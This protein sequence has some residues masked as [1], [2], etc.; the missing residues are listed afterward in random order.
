M[1]SFI[2]INVKNYRLISIAKARKL[3]PF[4]F[5]G[6]NSDQVNMADLSG[7][8]P[9][10]SLLHL[11]GHDNRVSILAWHAKSQLLASCGYDGTIRLWNI[12]FNKSPVL[13]STLVFH[14][15]TDIFGSEL[16][17]RH[18]GHLKWSPTGEYIA[19]AL[20]NIINVWPLNKSEETSCYNDWFIEDQKEFITALVWPRHRRESSSNKE[21]L[22][23]G[24]MDG[25][26]TL[27]T[28]HKEKKQAETLSN[29]SVPHCKYTVNLT[30]SISIFME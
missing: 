26:V 23:V 21:Y 7:F 18:I 9:Q 6:V 29:F 25:S 2:N 14:M 19:A 16:Q 1:Y 28:I 3:D 10:T 30:N 22:C 20:D 15:S 17:G 27:M 12:E 5:I 8:M 4:V 13:D 24:K 11:E